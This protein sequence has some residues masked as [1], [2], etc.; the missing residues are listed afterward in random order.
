MAINPTMH[1]RQ[2]AAGGHGSDLRLAEAHV[3]ELS[4]RD[5]AVLL[6]QKGV[7]QHVCFPCG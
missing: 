1:L 2:I 4:P 5:D 6:P 7:D 3:E